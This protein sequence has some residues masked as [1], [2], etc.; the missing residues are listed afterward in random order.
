MKPHH[1]LDNPIWSSLTTGHAH[2]ALG[3]DVGH[4]LA[5][6]YPSYIG[7][8][9]A[10]REQTSEA[11]AELA[12]IVPNEDIAALLL[13][14]EPEP[15]KGWELLRGGGIVQMVC[16][17]IPDLPGLAESIV[18]M[19]AFDNPEM[20]ALATLTEPGPFRDRTAELGG[21][22]GIRIEGRL[23]AMAGQRLFPDG[24]SEVSAV[25]THPDFRGRGY[26]KALVAAVS[27]NIHLSGRIPFLTSFQ[28]NEGA[29]RIYQQV[30]FLLRRTFQLAV[31]KPPT[32]AN[33]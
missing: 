14:N 13:D 31:L 18:P 32:P 27:R 17:R 5:R 4:G 19:T 8:L 21:F 6:R 22:V 29:I 7:P 15:L 9:S 10:L 20:V 3:S 30:G 28:A 33:R 12:S 11:Y 23:A 1:L 2:L 25:C 26:A 24:F 16:P